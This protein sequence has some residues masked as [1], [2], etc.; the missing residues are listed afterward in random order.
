MILRPA[1][2]TQP[3]LIGQL[4]LRLCVFLVLISAGTNVL[5]AQKHLEKRVTLSVTNEPLSGVLQ[6]IGT[7]GDFFFSYNSKHIP[8]DSLV[9]FNIRN[10][11]VKI[12]LDRLIGHKV[13]YEEKD[14][15]IILKPK[16]V[17]ERYAALSGTVRDTETGEWIDFASVYSKTTLVSALTDQEGAF[18]L[19]IREKALPLELTI[20]RVGYYDTTFVVPTGGK[21]QLDLFLRPK[22]IDLEEVIVT[23]E[24]GIQR[25]LSRMLLSTRM[26]ITSMNMANF[27][28][29]FRYQ[30]SLTPGLGTHGRM[31]AQVSNKVSVNIVGGYT[32]GADGLEIAGGFN[33]SSNDVRYVQ[34]AGVFNM[35]KGTVSGLQVAGTFNNV[36]GEV[37]GVQAAGLSNTNHEG[38]RG[39]QAAGLVNRTNRSVEGVQ[40]AGLYNRAGS[41]MRGLQVSGLIN[42]SKG[43]AKGAQIG[44]FNKTRHLKGLQIGL[45]NVADSTNGISLGL[46]NLIRYSPSHLSVFASDLIPL[47]LAWKTG[48]HR[49][50]SIVT[51]G[52]DVFSPT[53][54]YSLG[55]G[56][57]HTSLL[58]KKMQVQWEIV[59]LNFYQNTFKNSPNAYR[60]QV[61]PG[62]R[63]AKRVTLVA[64]PSLTYLPTRRNSAPTF[65]IPSRLNMKLFGIEHLL[66]GWTAGLNFYYG[67]RL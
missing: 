45:I 67:R 38:I 40:L 51:V 42:R 47:N 52:G 24:P 20:S 62:Y 2:Y 37:S 33:I 66:V 59:S 57:G 5:F 3:S 48:S 4:T 26:R 55:L 41:E 49:L 58:T 31:S 30:L 28:V 36:T 64:G 32:G 35:V 29:N 13:Q 61:L 46:F 23:N 43:T 16:E 21:Q 10:Q 63:V 60:L 18:R 50:Y 27:L 56:I 11:E 1:L 44:L 19:R 25:F 8:E 9:S 53:P 65:E 7:K 39:I 15:Y 22:T 17:M 14:Q 6:K 12:L 34:G 54:T